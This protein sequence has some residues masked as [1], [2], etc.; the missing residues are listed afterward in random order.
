MCHD[1]YRDARRQRNGLNPV[2][3]VKYNMPTYNDA[4]AMIV[5]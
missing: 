2:S 1:V 3:S 5:I 4:I